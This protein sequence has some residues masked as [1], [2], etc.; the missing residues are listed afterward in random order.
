VR[1][2]LPQDYSVALK[3]SQDVWLVVGSA[4]LVKTAY[5]AKYT[6]KGHMC[7]FWQQLNRGLNPQIASR[8]IKKWD[9]HLILI[10]KFFGLRNGHIG[11][12][13]CLFED[14]SRN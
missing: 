14:E 9:F 6:T 12:Q 4:T 10:P 13:K 11:G 5:K 2:Q 3:Y 8:S 7:Q 1:D